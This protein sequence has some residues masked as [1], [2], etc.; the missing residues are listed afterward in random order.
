[1]ASLDNV[2]TS[3]VSNSSNWDTAYATVSG[4]SGKVLQ[5][6]NFATDDK[7]FS[8]TSTTMTNVT[9]LC[10]A[11]TPISELND[12]LI[13]ANVSGGG[14]SDNTPGIGLKRDDTTQIGSSTKATGSVRNAIASKKDKGDGNGITGMAFTH[15]DS[16]SSTG[17]VQYQI[18]VSCRSGYTFRLNRPNDDNAQSNVNTVSTITLMEIL[19][20]S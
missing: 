5:V 16:P 3:V 7:T 6:I 2:G 11:I 8:T 15:M 9:D 20:V 13:I 4:G 18:T 10:A 12:I 17:S 14:S 19:V 1:M